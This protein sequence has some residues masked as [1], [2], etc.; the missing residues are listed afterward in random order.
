M[1]K[2]PLAEVFGFPLIIFPVLSLP[3]QQTL[4]DLARDEV[5]NVACVPQR[6]PFRYAGGK[7]WLVPRI[8]R[9]LKAKP[10]ELIEPFA[11]GGIVGLTA[12]AERL[13]AHITMVEL[14]EQVA[15]V[16]R[17]VINDGEG[18][19]LAEKIAGFELTPESLKRALGEKPPG[20]RE[21]AFQTI[22]KNRT[23][24]GGILAP[25]SAPLKHG[26]NGKGIRSR[27]YPETL[28]R[29]ILDIHAMREHMTFIEGD[30]LEIIRRNARRTDVAFFIDPPYTAA[31][32]KA[33]RRLYTHFDLDHDELFRAVSG[34]K[35][36]FLM[37]YDDAAGVRELAAR[38]GFDTELVAM[39]NTHHARMNELL[40]GFDLNWLRAGTM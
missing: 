8:R 32:K 11:G 15:A 26:E 3:Q 13:A 7:T 18:A 36:D 35:G 24:R 4:L 31:G 22:L 17:T 10:A 14:D 38:R 33:G 16:W 25:G 20:V 29:R 34:I 12:A 5:V 30:G 40:I 9:W 21:R 23:F 39:K 37:T 2:Q 19:W 27:W 6:S 1:P 28:K